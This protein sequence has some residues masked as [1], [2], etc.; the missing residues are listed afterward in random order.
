MIEGRT[1]GEDDPPGA[2]VVNRHFAN[3]HWPDQSAVGR[4]FRLDTGTWRT[5]VGVVADVRSVT[6]DALEPLPQVYHRIG[7]NYE[8]GLAV[9]GRAASTIAEE[10]TL[11]VRLAEPSPSR[12]A[13]V[14]ALARIDSNVIIAINMVDNKIANEIGRSRLVFALML[15]FAVFALFVCATGLYGL[16]AYSVEQRYREIGIRIALGAR[17]V[18]IGVHVVVT[19]LWVTGAA[20]VVGLLVATGLV[21]FLRSELYGV[22]PSDPLT[23]AV[24]SGTLALTA[25]LAAWQPAVRAAR[26]DPALLLRGE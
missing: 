17:P 16:V 20:I 24:V 9:A 15:G 4:R 8:G 22:S 13:I 1:F 6:T 21:Q 11:A 2:V 14:K 5:I 12:E 25:A 23:I 19:A 26:V 7:V 18:A 10:R 3:L